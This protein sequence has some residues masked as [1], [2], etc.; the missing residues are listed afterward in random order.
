MAILGLYDNMWLITV[1]DPNTPYKVA[2]GH[3]IKL[4]RE[5]PY[6]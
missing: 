5:W 3:Y 1:N 2:S 6:V 4:G